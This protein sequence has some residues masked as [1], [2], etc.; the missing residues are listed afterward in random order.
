MT[1][2]NGHVKVR[3]SAAPIDEEVRVIFEELAEQREKERIEHKRKQEM[4]PSKPPLRWDEIVRTP[5]DAPPAIN[6]PLSPPHYMVSVF[7]GQR[8][9]RPGTAQRDPTRQNAIR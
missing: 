3:I 8:C 6:R 1:R 5:A 4:V 2:M 7:V 9:P